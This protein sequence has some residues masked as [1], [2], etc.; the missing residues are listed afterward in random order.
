LHHKDFLAGVLHYVVNLFVLIAALYVPLHPSSLDESDDLHVGLIWLRSLGFRFG[1]AF[2]V[3][4]V[5][6]YEGAS[7]WNEALV[8]ASSDQ[9]HHNFQLDWVARFIRG[10][11]L[12]KVVEHLV[13]DLPPQV[14]LGVFGIVVH[15][16][17]KSDRPDE[18]T[19]DGVCSLAL[20]AG[21]VPHFRPHVVQVLE[22][23]LQETGFAEHSYLGVNGKENDLGL[24]HV[25]DLHFTGVADHDLRSLIENALG[26]L[27]HA[28]QL[29]DDP[30][31]DDFD[32][33]TGQYQQAEKCCQMVG[34]S[35]SYKK[36]DVVLPKS[37]VY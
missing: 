4:F 24:I 33:G 31:D 16:I 5:L 19:A 36:I 7:E 20:E 22:D 34:R 14:V 32:L 8:F 18:L 17:D 29:L 35:E 27:L 21:L 3:G 28:N 13:Y 12:E 15:F 23:E 10:E 6:G 2:V 1:R 9:T 30:E 26:N 11:I 37:R 25:L